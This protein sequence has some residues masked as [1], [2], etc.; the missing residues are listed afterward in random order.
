M[1]GIFG[2]TNFENQDL[3]RARKAL[4]CLAHRGPDQWGDYISQGVYMGHRRLSIIDLSEQGK[5]PMRSE[6]HGVVITV[7]GEIYN[8]RLL[9]QELELKYHFKSNSDSEVVLHGYTEWGIDGLLERM[10]GM[11]AISIFDTKRRQLFLV[12]DRAGI[13]PLIFS[14]MDS[15]YL[16][17]SEL[18]AIVEFVGEDSLQIDKTAIY[19][20]YTYQYIPTPKTL[21]QNV[22]KLE[23]GHYLQID[24]ESNAIVKKKYWVLPEITG[25]D[26]IEEASDKIKSLLGESVKEQFVSDVPVGLFLSGGMDSSAVVALASMQKSGLSTFNIGFENNPKD[27]S[28]YAELVAA[29]FK[30]NHFKKVLNIEEANWLYKS[31]KNWYDEPFGD[32][33]CLP[34]YLVSEF[35][36]NHVTVVLTGDGGDELFGGYKWY[37][38]FSFIEKFNLRKLRVLKRPVLAIIRLL[39]SG[40]FRNKIVSRVE[41]LFLSE[42]ELYTRLMGGRLKND[43]DK[44]HL[45]K[46]L[47]I[48]EDYDDYWYF[49]KFYRPE[50]SIYQRLRYLD[51]HTYLHDDILTKVDRVSMAV[52]L[53]CRVP[54]LSRKMMEY[55]FTLPDKTILHGGELKGAMKYAFKDILPQAII[56]RDKE[57]FNLPISTWGGELRSGFRSRQERILAE[58]F[59]LIQ[60]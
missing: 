60:H 20:F 59:K 55:M 16:W 35:A 37:K 39:L 17:A 48:S 53:E 6:E 41:W 22:F 36:K 21:Y 18:K 27:E 10:D 4:N 38:A 54:F 49:R 14:N 24:T 12:R 42:M 8:F 11:Y 32:L 50:M 56:N 9:R 44:I 7:N 15:R 25:S 45:K 47:S 26:S 52:A 33:S 57:G 28:P 51:F 34:T 31:I 5:Q 43:I 1:C 2:F 40:N 13:K 46:E 29:H 23:P 58:V 30:T 3:Q 19:D